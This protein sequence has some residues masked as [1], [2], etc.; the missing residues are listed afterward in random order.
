LSHGGRKECWCE[1]GAAQAKATGGA[2]GTSGASGGDE[3][4]RRVWGGGSVFIKLARL[5]QGIS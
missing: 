1:F 5:R 2:S 4:D 3:A